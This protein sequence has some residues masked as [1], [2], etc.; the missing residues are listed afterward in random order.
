MRHCKK[1]LECFFLEEPDYNTYKIYIKGFLAALGLVFDKKIMLDMT[2][3]FQRKF[4]I[5]ANITE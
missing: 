1:V 3:G 2:F 5:E 4:K